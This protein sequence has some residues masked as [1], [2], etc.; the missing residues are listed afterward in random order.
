MYTIGINRYI[1]ENITSLI[2]LTVLDTYRRFPLFSITFILKEMIM[3]VIQSKPYSPYGRFFTCTYFLGQTM[4]HILTIL[5][6]FMS[7][8]AKNF[9]DTDN[10]QE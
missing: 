1:N 7:L 3:Y 6:N 10:Q 4:N 5:M 8:S 9:C 2:L